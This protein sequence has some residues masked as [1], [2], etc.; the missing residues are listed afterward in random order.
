M[1]QQC[2]PDDLWIYD[3]LILSSKLGYV[4]GPAGVPVPEPGIY[5]VR[6]I[7]NIEGMGRDVQFIRL[8]DNTQHLPAGHFWCEVFQGRHL[9]VD[10]IH[11]DQVLCVEGFRTPTN[12][13]YRWDRWQ[14]VNTH[15]PYPELLIEMSFEKVN[16]EFIDGKLIEVHL[17]HNPNFEDRNVS[18]VIPVW[19]D[20]TPVSKPG[21]TFV[22]EPDYERIGFYVPNT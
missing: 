12:P 21:Y 10:Y 15:V 5:I 2:D 1:W 8:E 16:C 17:R 7:T 11:G 6:P 14:R 18:H 4:C 22:E 13:A 3:K 20:Q 19:K 9:S